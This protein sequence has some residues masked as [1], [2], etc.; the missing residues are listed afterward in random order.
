MEDRC[1]DLESEL[2][3][4]NE[5]VHALNASLG[6]QQQDLLLLQRQFALLAEEVRTLRQSLAAPNHGDHETADEKP[7]HY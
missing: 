1:S 6:Q 7:P 2:A 3:Y 5:T 4:Q